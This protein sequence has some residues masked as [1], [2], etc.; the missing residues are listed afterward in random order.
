MTNLELREAVATKV[1]GAEWERDSLFV[2]EQVDTEHRD[3]E[4]RSWDYFPTMEAALASIKSMPKRSRA[5]AFARVEMEPAY[6]SDIAAAWLVV[7]KMR[8]RGWTDFQLSQVA[9]GDWLC[10]FIDR[11][12]KF[13]GASRASQASSAPLAICLAALESAH[14]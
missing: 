3:G 12:R 14:E 11:D 10:L 6:E 5:R 13:G 8:E 7:E 4:W 1:M 9:S 2:A